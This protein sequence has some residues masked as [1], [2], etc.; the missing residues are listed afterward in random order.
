[1]ERKPIVPRDARGDVVPYATVTLRIA[2]TGE[3]ATGL[4]DS[5][6][7]ENEVPLSNPFTVDASG[8][9]VIRAPDGEYN[10]QVVKDDLDWTTPYSF[11]DVSGQVGA[12]EAAQEAAELAEGA[13]LNYRNEARQ[14][15]DE[16]AAIVYGG[17]YSVEPAA[18]S[19]PISRSDGTLHPDWI[20]GE[21]S[22]ALVGHIK[23][24]ID[25]ASQAAGAV[26][27]G[28]VRVATGAADRPSICLATNPGTGIFF[29]ADDEI[30]FAINGVEVLRIDSSGIV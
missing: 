13:A 24:A 18:G 7:A 25:M 8:I 30:A 6:D 11:L 3:L 23:Y 16:A 2:A 14:A 10:A 9:R 22:A 27:G 26:N 28:E 29:P 12:A 4:I 21:Y 19:V 5:T 17:D 20:A 15:R 1:M